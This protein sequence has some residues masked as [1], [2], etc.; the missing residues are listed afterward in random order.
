MVTVAIVVALLAIMA[1]GLKL[2]T[3]PYIPPTDAGLDAWSTNFSALL[4]A[5]PATYGLTRR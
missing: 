3:A 5:S 2:S 1:C 4:T